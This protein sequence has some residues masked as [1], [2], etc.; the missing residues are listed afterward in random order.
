LSLRVLSDVA[1]S[2]S[3]S[4]STIKTQLSAIYRKLGVSS[5][6]HAIPAAYRLGLLERG[7]TTRTV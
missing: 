5:R 2:L 7:S 1:K 3:V 6:H 4:P